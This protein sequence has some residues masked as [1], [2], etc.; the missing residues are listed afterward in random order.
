MTV[1]RR[2]L[3]LG[4]AARGG[5]PSQSPSIVRASARV[6]AT[7][8][9]RPPGQSHCQWRAARTDERVRLVVP[10]ILLPSSPVQDY[11]AAAGP[12]QVAQLPVDRAPGDVHR[13]DPSPTQAKARQTM[14]WHHAALPP[15]PRKQLWGRGRA[16]ESRPRRHSHGGKRGDAVV[17]E[18]GLAPGPATRVGCVLCDLARPA[19]ATST[20]RVPGREE[21][22]KGA[23]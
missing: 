19:A 12:R 21:P 8:S 1:Q 9:R 4:T 20:T 13:Y 16:I 10:R 7:S 23:R 6:R 17:R 14:L 3:N 5:G 15:S 18:A 11:Y 2:L 22:Y